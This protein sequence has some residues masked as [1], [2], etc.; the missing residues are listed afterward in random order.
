M[1]MR[2]FRSRFFLMIVIASDGELTIIIIG[3]AK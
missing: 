2:I 1:F 3:I